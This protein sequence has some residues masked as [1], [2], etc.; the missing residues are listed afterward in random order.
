MLPKDFLSSKAF[1]LSFLKNF[2]IPS[3][4]PLQSLLISNNFTIFA[5]TILTY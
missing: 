2:L 5:A 3:F 1:L 4:S